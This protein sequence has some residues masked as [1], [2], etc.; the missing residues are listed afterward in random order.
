MDWL[1]LFKRR[2]AVAGL[3]L[4]G[5]AAGA[6]AIATAFPA[7]GRNTIGPAILPLWAAGIFAA[8]GLLIA[9]NAIIRERAIIAIGDIKPAVFIALAFVVF[10]LLI[11][12][13]G[14]MVATLISAFV[15]GMA[16]VEQ[17]WRGR[18]VTAVILAGAAALFFVELLGLPLRLVVWPS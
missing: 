6:A 13:F 17:S 5:L 3:A 9:A 10:A 8:A 16:I 11:E 7:G 4:I 14:L 1:S 18:L 15:A 2:D 12:R